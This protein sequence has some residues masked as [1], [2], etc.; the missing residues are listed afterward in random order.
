MAAMEWDYRE[1]TLVD[2][3][4]Y[5]IL[6]VLKNNH[7]RPKILE[8]NL[9][10]A[11]PNAMAEIMVN[12]TAIFD[13]TATAAVVYYDSTSAEDTA[14]T[15]DGIR[16]IKILSV[17]EDG[18]DYQENTDNMAGT[19]GT[20]TTE[21]HQRLIAVKGMSAGA[22]GD[23]EGTI[24]IQDDAAGTN[25]HMTIAAG[26]VSSISARLYLPDDWK[27]LMYYLRAEVS[28]AVDANAHTA[29]DGALFIPYVHDATKIAGIAPDYAEMHCVNSQSG[30]FELYNATPV[31]D[32][33]DGANYITLLHGALDTDTN[34]VITYRIIYIMWG[35]TNA[36]RGLPS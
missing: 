21:K 30:P 16:T 9:Q 27:G 1:P 7:Y 35:T 13:G 20:A 28:G 14:T 33:N 6:R 11:A 2:F 23:A 36:Q 18:D 3:A 22:N 19:S 26:D 5:P 17:N 24:T 32:S 4:Q 15:G 29:N 12:Y 34:M 10:Q 8:L 31:V 25:K